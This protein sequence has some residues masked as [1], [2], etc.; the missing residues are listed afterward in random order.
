MQVDLLHCLFDC[1]LVFRRNDGVL[2]HAF[3]LS[4]CLGEEIVNT[5]VLLGVVSQQE[6]VIFEGLDGAVFLALCSL[7]HFFQAYWLSNPRTVARG[8]PLVD[9]ISEMILG[10]VLVAVLYDADDGPVQHGLA[11]LLR[12]PGACWELGPFL[13]LHIRRSLAMLPPTSRRELIVHLCSVRRSSGF[14]SS[15]LR[16]ILLGLTCWC[17]AFLGILSNVQGDTVGGEPVPKAT[18]AIAA[19]KSSV[20][21]LLLLIL[22]VAGISV[23]RILR[24]QLI[25]SLHDLIWLTLAGVY[26]ILL[27]FGISILDSI[28]LPSQ[29]WLILHQHWLILI[30]LSHFEVA[31]ILKLWSKILLNLD[32]AWSSLI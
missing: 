18:T 22:Q 4:G 14:L 28:A 1:V 15:R 12:S 6:H 21:V 27:I 13:L 19:T 30:L 11:S 20:I 31:D 16:C 23:L 29:A 17:L 10:V 9:W 7:A 25:R 3:K 24:S 26:H 32:G 2:G 5:V 8:K